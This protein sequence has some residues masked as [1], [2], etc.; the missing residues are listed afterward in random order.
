MHRA[1]RWPKTQTGVHQYGQCTDSW[2][3]DL[4]PVDVRKTTFGARLAVK[5]GEDAGTSTVTAHVESI[6][7]LV[8][9]CNPDG[10]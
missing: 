1:R 8:C 10:K 6:R 2:T 4:N 3:V 5:R 7:M 9:Y